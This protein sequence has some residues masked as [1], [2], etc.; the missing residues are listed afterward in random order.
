MVDNEPDLTRWHYDPAELTVPAGTTVVW[1]N[2]GKEEH[3]VTADDKS[4]D[5]G[6][7]GRGGTFQRAFPRPGRY[8]YHCAPHPW[9]KGA[10]QVV[11]AARAA[12]SAPGTEPTAAPVSTTATTAAP[13]ATTFPPSLAAPTGRPAAAAETTTS[14][15]GETAAPGET[16]TS[17]PATEDIAAPAARGKGSGGGLPGT[18]AVVLLPTLAGLAIGA[19]LRQSTPHGKTEPA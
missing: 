10:V 3:T 15:P 4:F 2:K 11:A 12:A 1:L 13:T 6:M 17:A 14:A 9:M 18:I 5:S 8:T 7:K 16:T 19:K